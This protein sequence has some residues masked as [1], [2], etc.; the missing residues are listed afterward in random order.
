[1]YV[2]AACHEAMAA[3]C[4]GPNFDGVDYEACTHKSHALPARRPDAMSELVALYWLYLGIADGMSIA[5][6]WACR[7]S[8]REAV[9]LS[10]GTPMPA[11]W[12]CRRQCQDRAD[13]ELPEA[14]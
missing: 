14:D 10:I 1:M 4:G 9:I 2:W 6:V 13:I 7:Y 3:K 11:Q 5:R 8:K 12:T